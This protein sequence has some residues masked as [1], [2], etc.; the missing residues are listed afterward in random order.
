MS[1][2]PLSGITVVDVSAL[3]PGPFCTMIL[4]DFGADVVWVE[5]IDPPPFDVASFFAPGKRSI[6]VDLRRPEGAATVAH[7]TRSAD[8]FVEGS[9]PGTMERLGLGPDE[10]RAA[11][12]RLVYTRLTGWGQD[13]PYAHRA[14]H[15]INYLALSGALGVLGG[16]PPRPP[17]NLVGDF[18]SGSVMAAF[19][20]LIALFDRQRTGAGQVVDAAMVDGAAQLIA[21]QLAL[22][23][24]GRW[25]ANGTDLLDG[26]A[27]FYRCFRCADG[28]HLAVGAVEPKF[29]VAFLSGLGADPALAA[30]QF[31][32][33]TWAATSDSLAAIVASRSRDEW[34]E[35][36]HG[37]DACV[38]PVLDLDELSADPHLTAR[39]TITKGM[40]GIEAGPAPRLGDASATA[41][42]P[43]AAARGAHTIEVLGEAGLSPTEIDRLIASGA[44][45]A[46]G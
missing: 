28:R 22:F 5:P 39:G 34:V 44:I 21:A 7:L 14:G 33:G 23:N 30:I 19:G 46:A 25:R 45:A 27:P 38:T 15:D 1:P 40:A 35:H 10:L 20:T 31:D 36:F 11:N 18:A 26:S 43:P 12:P 13:G 29:Y 37:I 17:L 16:S 2:G 8:V 41:G 6:R 4:A 24:R 42:R 9:R 3:A 32:E